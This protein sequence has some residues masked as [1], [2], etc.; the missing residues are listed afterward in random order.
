MERLR[1]QLSRLPAGLFSIIVFLTIMWLTLSSKPLGENPPP[2]FPGADKLAHAIMFGGFVVVM[3]LDW[4]R[5]HG[6][7]RVGWIRAIICGVISSFVG[8]LV[9]FAQANM[10]LG[11]SFEYDDMTADTVGAFLFAV[12]YLILQK[13]WLPDTK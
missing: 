4:Q 7:K 6:W 13:E 2:M 5:K 12:S 10:G 3:L 9:E 1:N 11:R 8:I